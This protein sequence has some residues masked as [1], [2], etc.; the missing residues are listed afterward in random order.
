MRAGG[1]DLQAV[2]PRQVHDYTSQ[3]HQLIPYAC[4]GLA[5]GGADLDD[6]L[7]Q[8]GLD[9]LAQKEAPFI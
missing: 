6:R 1:G 3:P 4:W 7:V 5:H 9:L 8:L 2:L